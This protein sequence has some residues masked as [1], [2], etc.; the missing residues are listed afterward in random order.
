SVEDKICRSDVGAPVPPPVNPRNVVGVHEIPSELISTM[1]LVVPTTRL[2]GIVNPM[3]LCPSVAACTALF[4]P[5]STP[6]TGIASVGKDAGYS[7]G[8][9]SPARATVTSNTPCCFV[10]SMT[11][12]G[13]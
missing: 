5:V 12:L 1:M 4:D 11:R 8:I 6:S 7:P 2:F 3:E 13:L 10:L 9:H